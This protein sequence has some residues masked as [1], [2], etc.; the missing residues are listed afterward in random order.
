MQREMMIMVLIQLMLSAPCGSCNRQK[1]KLPNG[2]YR[3]GK[4]Y[5]ARISVDGKQQ[6]L[7]DYQSI[8]KAEQKY[9][10]AVAAKRAGAFQEFMQ[11]HYKTPDSKSLVH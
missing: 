2:V 3:N 1:R 11:Q 9:K 4:R 10:A 7:G 8:D 6:H 5:Q